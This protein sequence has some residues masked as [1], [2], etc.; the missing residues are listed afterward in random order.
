MTLPD[1]LSPDK[2]SPD[3]LSP[4]QRALREEQEFLDTAYAAL[5]ADLAYYTEQL[6]RVRAQ[7]GTGTPSAR[8]E[9]DSFATHYEDT[10]LRLRNVEHRLVLGRL[11][12]SSSPE[13]IH[14]GRITLRD[15]NK[16]IL[17]T[18][19]R[20]PQSQPFYQATAAHPG[21]IA[22]RRHIQTR[23][24][25]VTGVEDE[26]LQTRDGQT[27]DLDLSELNLTGEGALI[28]AISQARDGK[29]GDIVATIQAEQDRII[30]SN[31]KGIMVVQGGPGTGK[32]AV[33][34]H[35]AAYLLYA[36]RERLAHSGVLLI[37]PS[38]RFL[39][40]IDQVLPSL[41]ESNV[42]ALTIG[43]LF[44]GAR[45]SVTDSPE[46]AEIKSRI[47]W[48]TIAQRAIPQI[49]QKPLTRP[50]SVRVN[51]KKLT[52]TPDD[53]ATAQRRARQSGKPHNQ[54]RGT[55]ARYLVDLLAERLA[56]ALQ[57]SLSESDW[58]VRDIAEDPDIRREVNRH[59]LPAS[60]QW[61]LEHI[62]QWPEVLERVA[63]ELLPQEKAA[64][65]R[66]RGSGFSL[67]DI[68]LLDELAEHLGDFTSDAQRR[69]KNAQEQGEQQLESYVRDTMSSL[70]L[71]GGIVRS[72]DL[73]A[74]IASGSEHMTMAETAAS[75][76]S[77]TYG[78]VVVD[79]AQELTPMQW[80]MIARRNPARSMTIVGDVDQ[81]IHTHTEA[82]WQSIL[83]SLST[84]ARIERLTVSYRTPSSIL[85]RAAE[86]MAELGYPVQKVQGVRDVPDSYWS[87]QVSPAELTDA[88][89]TTA[90][91]LEEFLD[92]EY[93]QGLGSMAIIVPDSFGDS[94]HNSLR[95]SLHDSLREG[96]S[97]ALSEA[98][99]EALNARIYESSSEQGVYAAVTEMPRLCVISASGSKGLEY[100]AVIVVEPADIAAE[101]MGNLYV[102]L[103][104]AT[105]RLA[106]IAT[107]DMPQGLR[108]QA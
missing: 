20:A 47:I 88:V 56:A 103:T 16:D 67:A 28:A 95:D 41:G 84:H 104:R 24:R 2:L 80:A 107:R 10:V 98:L 3:E 59:W 14:I 1:E 70:G 35:R 44:P 34:L 79:E 101:S 92:S 65:Q 30:R 90:R 69:Q 25:S 22:R 51:G 31:S 94:L 19:W 83:G 71:G 106:V 86:T 75:D 40:Y 57:T 96:L 97:G 15:S 38:R 63:P 33:A 23:F 89:A 6:T 91:R 78:H 26:L 32:T 76:R 99:S 81:R 74:R 61:L 36:E 102:A 18:D 9:R 42:V 46:A 50:W 85:D 55:Y 93:G 29:M 13:H 73:L 72:A 7:G 105:K 54:A 58:L 52:L 100:D 27:S 82:T 4:T 77:W 108:F 66:D 53:V 39:Q 5:D 43:E 12:F 11:D 68:P 49:L 64:L 87:T 17:L 8:S 45:P 21:D 37:G 60:P 48:R 62:Y